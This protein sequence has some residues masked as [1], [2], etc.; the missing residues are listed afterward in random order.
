MPCN[1]DL[2]IDLPSGPSG[3]A[4]PGFGNPFAIKLPNLNPFPD[5]FP[6]DLLDLLNK[7]QMLLPSGILKP[8]LNPNFGKDIFDGIM[9]L[10]DMFFPF[11]MLYKFFL[12][13]LKLILCIIEVLCAL[14][15]PFK[16]IR[17][18]RRLFRNCIPEFLNLFPIFALIIMIISLLLLLLALIKY[19]IA[20]ILKLIRAILRNLKALFSAIKYKDDNSIIAIAKKLGSLLCI[21]QNLFVLLS[22]FNIIIQII[23]DIIGMS[24]SIPPCDDTDGT[25]L[26]GCCTPDVCPAIVKS[27]Y[28]RTTGSLQYFNKVLVQ[29]NVAMPPPFGTG[30]FLSVDVRNESWQIF[31]VDQE[32]A[33]KFINIVD[34]YDVPFT[35]KPV[36]FPTDS[37]YNALTNPKQAA[38]TVDLRMYYDPANWGRT[39]AVGGLP[40]FIRF[41]DCIVTLAP[42]AN[43]ISYNNGAISEPTGVLKL[44]GGLGYEDNGTT[45]ISGF[46]TDGVTPF[47]AQATLENFIHMPQ[48]ASIAPELLVTDGYMFSEL[49]YT[50][51]PNMNTLLSK[52][53]VTLGCEPSI[54]E[55]KTFINEVFAGDAAL[56]LGILGGLINGSSFPNTDE[57]QQC[58]TIAL[59][60]LR[61]N[62]TVQG[63]LDFQTTSLLCLSKLQDDTTNSLGE[64]IGLGFDAC[65]ST[66]TAGESS[67]S[68]VQ[69]TSK[70]IPIAVDLKERNGISLG[71]GIPT[72]I[73]DDLA[74]R[75]KAHITF[76]NVSNFAFDGYQFFT[77]DLTSDKPGIG[78]LMISF[79]N[80]IFCTNTI[81]ADNDVSPTHDLKLVNYQFVYTPV[82]GIGTKT[83]ETDNDGQPRRNGGD[84]T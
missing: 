11:L 55:N 15:N 50:F 23:K 58:L 4:I 5:G 21:F 66:F 77:A 27:E 79:D 47:S 69:F 45:A 31:D 70:A 33:Q 22:L 12:P 61:E 51:K 37:T 3:P 67:T 80:N 76:G 84:N 71:T 24:F 72:E 39:A 46:N 60:A 82:A 59:D 17:A 30:G 57:A 7:L 83:G 48:L 19:I 38:Y 68:I 44:A 53:I 36:F 56:K 43:L 14:K 63:V 29:T 20:Q 1:I 62:L 65:S 54:A 6:E 64:L 34:G 41:K 52:D 9:K 25:D 75:I 10:M 13:I 32:I 18:M 26:D 81:P 28:T 49:E 40:R 42:T 35:P 16:L 74:K 8:A 73:G 78:E 2:S